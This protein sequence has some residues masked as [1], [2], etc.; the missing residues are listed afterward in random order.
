MSGGCLSD[1][2]Y[3]QGGYDMQAID[4]HPIRFI[5]ITVFLF[6][7]LPRI[8]Q[9]VPYFGVSVGCLEGVWEAPGGCLSDSGHC[10]GGYGVNSFDKNPIWII[11]ISCVIFSQ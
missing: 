9:N 4:N 6:S 11:L 8:G 10:L 5:Y 7:Q 1:S 3:C 2:G